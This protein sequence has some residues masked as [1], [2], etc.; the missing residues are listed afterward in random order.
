[1]VWSRR[2]CLEPVEVASFL[3]LV[4]FKDGGCRLSPRSHLFVS[5]I[6]QGNEEACWVQDFLA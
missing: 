1:M 5:D 2:F 3:F 4:L 6:N